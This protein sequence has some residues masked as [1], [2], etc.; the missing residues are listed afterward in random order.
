M[1]G[2]GLYK[3]FERFNI[4]FLALLD[5]D[6]SPY[7]SIQARVEEL[8]RV[9]QR[10]S[11]CESQF[12]LGLVGLPGANNSAMRPDWGSHPF[13]FFDYAWDRFLYECSKRAQNAS[14]P[15]TE[16]SDFLVY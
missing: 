7:V 6:S 13:Q 8:G 1:S 12:H 16:L 3:F 10:G 2:R 14:S 5:V 9:F 4:N 15:V 11:F